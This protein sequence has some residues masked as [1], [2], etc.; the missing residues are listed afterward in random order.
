MS[1]VASLVFTALSPSVPAARV[2]SFT[3][4]PWLSALKAASWAVAVLTA[5]S[6]LATRYVMVVFADAPLEPELEPREP[7]LHADNAIEPTARPTKA[8]RAFLWSDTSLYLLVEEATAVAAGL[9]GL[10]CCL[11]YTSPS[12]RDRQ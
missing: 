11:L 4:T 7:A 6:S 10:W 8:T 1:P 5:V 3:V 9:H 12:P 2:S